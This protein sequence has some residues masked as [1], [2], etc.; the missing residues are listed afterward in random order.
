MAKTLLEKAQKAPG[1]KRY[2]DQQIDLALGWLDG[3]VSAKQISHALGFT[4]QNVY[5]WLS[6]RIKAAYEQGKITK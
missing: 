2:S 1:K 5:M 3:T 6:P 4:R